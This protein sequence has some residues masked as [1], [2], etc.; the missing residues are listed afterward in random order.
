MEVGVPR[1]YAGYTPI[2]PQTLRPDSLP[3]AVIVDVF[4]RQRLVLV[5]AVLL[6][7][8]FAHAQSPDEDAARDALRQGQV[9]AARAMSAYDV[10][11]P[12]QPLWSEAIEQGE[13]ARRLAPNDLAPVR[14]LA[15]VYT[16]TQWHFRAWR[17]WQAYLNAGGELDAQAR[18]DAAASALRLG[19]ER[20]TAGSPERALD[21]FEA[22]YDLNPEGA[23][24][25]GWLGR[26]YFELGRPEEAVPLLQQAVRRMP[27]VD[28]FEAYL[29]RAEHQLA[30][31]VV[32]S[33][34]FFEG[35]S[36]AS[37]GRYRDAAEAFQ[38]AVE[39]NPM[40]H[41]AMVAAAEAYMA[42][43]MPEDAIPYWEG[44]LAI[45][46][47]D[48]RSAFFLELAEDQ[49]AW[50]V[51]SVASFRQGRSLLQAGDAAG[52]ADALSTAVELNPEYA[53]AWALRAQ[54]EEALGNDQ[55]A[56][57]YYER[58]LAL[59]PGSA[60]VQ[61][62]LADVRARIE[63]AASATAAATAEGASTAE[64]DAAAETSGEA[65][66][67]TQE[68]EPEEAPA[69]TGEI[70]AD[71]PSTDEEEPEAEPSPTERA[72]VAAAPAGANAQPST[73]S[74]VF[75]LLDTELVHGL[76]SDA[77]GFRFVE[78]R[79]EL[80]PDLVTPVDYAGGTLLHRVEV[81]SKP[82]DRPVRYQLCLV[83]TDITR[84]PACTEE[85][86][87]TLTQPGVYTH[88]QPLPTLSQFSNV[89][90]SQGLDSLMVIVKDAAGNPID[91]SYP[92]REQF[93]GAPDL[94]LYYPMEVRYTVVLVPEDGT[95]VGWRAVE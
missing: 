66:S 24:A 44:A 21:L 74:G 60:D 41:E 6:S 39:A 93:E 16:T 90:W 15:Q 20:Y 30:Y 62:A 32:A 7:M 37:E 11:Y 10:H 56:V 52:A 45:Q 31:G 80:V 25:T 12:D 70:V 92:L 67:T 54:A 69:T 27:E 89:D 57:T 78:G 72:P 95:F 1:S 26:V 77:S 87:L 64:S 75:V 51:E 28:L 48:E 17:A 86:G 68:P 38:K 88:S 50:G 63:D 85:S 71:A 42:L 84:R 3:R 94:G 23:Q 33:N 14:F 81:V 79:V 73:T 29:D 2:R 58:A 76:G 22:A 55:N 61:A 9:A 40:F 18:R 83:P 34:A 53:A 8:V 65:V 91:G 46:P 5:L 36:A 82:T 13:R 43:D 59:A 35:A 4:R 47:E 49:L 19:Y